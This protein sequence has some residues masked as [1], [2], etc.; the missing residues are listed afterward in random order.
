MG[1]TWL[2]NRGEEGYYQN[3]LEYFVSFAP[4]AEALINEIDRL[5]TKGQMSQRTR[6]II[7]EVLQDIGV[8]EPNAY[9]D[10]VASALFLASISPD[11][12]IL[13]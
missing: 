11:F 2:A 5:L 7:K 9:R 12:V 1:Y 13:K 6:S 4:D 10:R 3:N 8:Y